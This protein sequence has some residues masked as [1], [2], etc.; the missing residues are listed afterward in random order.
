MSI[1]WKSVQN[2]EYMW[3]IVKANLFFHVHVPQMLCLLDAEV[4][5]L[6]EQELLVIL[7]I[8]FKKNVKKVI[9]III[10]K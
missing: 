7:M 6:D 8:F 9:L 2:T 1:T 5:E 10:R 3:S 4:V